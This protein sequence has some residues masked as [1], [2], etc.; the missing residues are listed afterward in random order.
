[1]NAP[2]AIDANRLGGMSAGRRRSNP[3]RVLLVIALAFALGWVASVAWTATGQLRLVDRVS[4]TVSVVNVAGA[5]ICLE[6][7]GGGQQRC[8]VVYQRPD[9]ASLEVGD[10]VSVAVGVLRTGPDREE[11]IFVRLVSE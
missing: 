8:S 10:H 4:G 3:W 7:D 9:A 2:A 5:A 1:M 11:E 6:P